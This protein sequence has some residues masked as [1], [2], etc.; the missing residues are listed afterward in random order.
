MKAGKWEQSVSDC[1][2]ATYARH[3]NTF[4]PKKINYIL[5]IFAIFYKLN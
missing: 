1:L 3:Y 5:P 4:L 2:N